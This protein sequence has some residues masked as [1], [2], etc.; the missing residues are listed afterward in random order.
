MVP[1]ESSTFVEFSQEGMERDMWY[2]LSPSIDS[3][4]SGNYKVDLIVRFSENYPYEKLY[5]TIEQQAPAFDS[6]WSKTIDLDLF[7]KDGVPE[8]RHALGINEVQYAIEEN[9]F[10]PPDFKMYVKTTVDS[11]PGIKA[12]GVAYK[13]I[14]N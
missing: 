2:D 13:Y 1:E 5:L 11:T 8:G 9:V 10:L 6:V 12:M 7:R 14:D 4:S 3:V